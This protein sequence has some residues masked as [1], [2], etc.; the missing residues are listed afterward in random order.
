MDILREKIEM[1]G[2]MRESERESGSKSDERVKRE[3]QREQ[4]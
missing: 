3:I 4:E 2:V 1:K